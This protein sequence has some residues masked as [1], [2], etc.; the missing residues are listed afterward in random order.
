MIINL[1]AGGA[2][3]IVASASAMVV[4]HAAVLLKFAVS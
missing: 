2:S 4:P 3:P 1:L